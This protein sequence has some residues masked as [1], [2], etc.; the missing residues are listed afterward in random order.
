M[1]LKT[2]IA[3]I[4]T[5]TV[6]LKTVLPGAAVDNDAAQRAGFARK[7]VGRNVLADRIYFI[8]SVRIYSFGYGLG[9][10]MPDS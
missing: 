2:C 4:S 1:P 8:A 3:A 9:S 7:P 5:F 6:A 10:M